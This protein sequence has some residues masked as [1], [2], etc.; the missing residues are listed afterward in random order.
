MLGAVIELLHADKGNIQL[1]DPERNVLTIAVQ[2]GFDEEFLD[3]FREIS[4]NDD[5]A[6][7]R[8]L[9]SREPVVIEDVEV[10]TPYAPLRPI[11]RAAGYRGVVSVPLLGFDEQPLGMLS[12]HFTSPHRPTTEELR[13]LE[14]YARQAADFIERC[15]V[16][17]ALKHSQEVLSRQAR[18]LDLSYD[19][20]FVHDLSNRIL[21]WNRGAIETYGYTPEEALGRV[22]RELLHTVFPD[23]VTAI[24]DELQRTGRW[25]GELEHTR[26]DG[27]KI[28]VSSR[29]A[30]SLNGEDA[31]RS[32]MEI[33]RDITREREAEGK[34]RKYQEELEQR[35]WARTSE[36]TEANRLLRALS[37]KLLKAQDEERRRIARDL[38][39]SVGQY[40]AAVAM[41][42]A[43]AKA[44]VKDLQPSLTHQLDEGSEATQ[45]CL[46][47]VRTIS[48]LLHP[49]LLEEGGLRA[50]V[51]QYV[52]EFGARSGIRVLLEAPRALGRMDNDVEIVLFRVLQES[53]TNVHRHSGS[54]TATVRIVVDPGKVSLE[55][56][57]QGKG[58]AEASDRRSSSEPFHPGVGITG[59]RERVSNVGGFV[60]ITAD[61]SGT[62]M[63]VV[64]PVSA[65][66]LKI[67][68]QERMASASR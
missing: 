5:S 20:I 26:K 38:H 6:C 32:I 61:G 65:Q 11:A 35:V 7:G 3:F 34:I 42:L 43:A 41:A 24:T 16:D 19:A 36:L 9:R 28:T 63:R 18:L 66:P 53:L 48:Y 37:T 14:L 31:T 49:P 62:L 39:D 8:A 2:R 60:E 27:E 56:Q 23:S 10:D 50:A 58:A 57:D 30:L 21:Y 47:E 52:E 68:A 17:A 46:A 29:W 51:E 33:N 59:I 44:E 55:V 64:I 15:R 22:A 54:K 12:T 25:S 1:L 13:R 40:L 45:A 4:S 67:K